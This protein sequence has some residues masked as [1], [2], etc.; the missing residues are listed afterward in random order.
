MDAFSFEV[1]ELPSGSGERHQ[2]GE[3]HEVEEA[4]RRHAERSPGDSSE[5]RDG[6]D[7]EQRARRRHVPHE[8]RPQPR[9]RGAIPPPDSPPRGDEEREYKK[10]EGEEDEE[11]PPRLDVDIR[12]ERFSERRRVAVTKGKGTDTQQ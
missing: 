1:E 8:R 6:A 2:Q 9:E 7:D 5:D 12:E 3:R 10:S 11:E 4:F